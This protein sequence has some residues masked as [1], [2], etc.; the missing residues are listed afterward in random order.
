MNK[1]PGRITK[2][3]D[4]I[5]FV[6][7]DGGN[8]GNMATEDRRK[9]VL[10]VLE[11]SGVAMKSIDVFRN[12]K[13]RGSTFE[14][15]TTKRYLTQLIERGEVLKVDSKALNDGEIKEI[16]TEETGHFI[17]ASVAEQYRN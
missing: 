9:Q 16:K 7:S 12:C 17:A 5:T 11:E 8:M 10:A 14:R 2:K 13:L 15:R 3:S 6:K 4:R 1:P